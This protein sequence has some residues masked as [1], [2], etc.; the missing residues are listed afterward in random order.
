LLLPDFS[1]RLT[2]NYRYEAIFQI[3]S[4]IKD[5]NLQDKTKSSKFFEIFFMKKR[6]KKETFFEE[7]CMQ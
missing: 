4:N 1:I 5:R 2:G 7:K 3:L 6:I